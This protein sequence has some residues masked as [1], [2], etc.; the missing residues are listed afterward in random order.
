VPQAAT[1]LTRLKRSITP[2]ICFLLLLTAVFAGFFATPSSAQSA[3]AVVPCDDAVMPANSPPF[4]CNGYGLNTTYLI[5]EDR[6]KSCN[7]IQVVAIKITQH[8]IRVREGWAFV[9]SETEFTGTAFPPYDDYEF[10]VRLDVTGK[11]P[12]LYT[13]HIDYSWT[14]T[15]NAANSVNTATCTYSG[16]G[17]IPG[18]LT[19]N[20]VANV[21]FVD[22]VGPA[23]NLMNG[24]ITL[25]TSQLQ[26]ASNLTKGT[27][28][29]G[30]GADG[31]TEILIRIS[32]NSPNEQFQLTLMNDA[33]GVSNSSDEDGALGSP[34]DS[35]FTANQK[36]VS[37][38][39]AAPGQS[40]YAFAI[41][42]APIDFVRPGSKQGACMAP[43]IADSAA[44]CRSVSVK[45][46]DLTTNTSVGNYLVYIL[47]PPV[48]LIHGL[49][50]D[51]KAWD[52]FKPLIQGRQIY[53]FYTDSRFYARP[54]DYSIPPDPPIIGFT[55]GFANVFRSY[56]WIQSNAL[57]FV[58]NAPRVAVQVTRYLNTFKNGDNPLELPI[59]ASQVD[60][61]GHSM[62]G[63][64]ARQMV[65]QTGQK[66]Y[67]NS[68]NFGQGTIHKLITIDTPHLG[69][70]L[71]NKLIDP[72]NQCVRSV[73]EGS[74]SYSVNIATLSDGSSVR[75]AMADLAVL[76]NQSIQNL[77]ATGPK[78][79][80]AAL[81]AG[82]YTN[83][84]SLDC[85]GYS[86]FTGMSTS[87]HLACQGEPLEQSLNSSGWPLLFGPTG[88]NL[89][90]GIVSVTS[91]FNNGTSSLLYSS[92]V[93]TKALTSFW[94]GL[95]FTSPSVLDHASSPNGIADEVIT[96]LNTPISQAPF[97]PLNP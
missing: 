13:F 17:T 43:V 35:I 63:L 26:L 15:A 14:I 82:S 94:K 41:Y 60:I 44:S 48:V 77:Q 24:Y 80:S 42:R 64:I 55:P 73:F 33:G 50:S 96:L 86:C 12:G 54:V 83:W 22:P 85:S 19:L 32:T 8:S 57:G 47:R 46:Q 68:N 67:L 9:D 58:Y 51:W 49:W 52:D 36:T 5:S 93:H 39:T 18:I 11:P 10:T 4:D 37:A 28:I 34:G 53:R 16:N 7:G 81:L 89:N 75:G 74:G 45:V 91:Q 20:S 23:P 76:P 40:A 69:S 84:S 71:A 6:A 3:P 62:G 97:A 70:I 38:G 95:N 90:D 59:A 56:D 29:N 1:F 92:L 65:L 2:N 79:L 72:A 31:V 87:I 30:V 21:I 66:P 61:I 88:N 27:I 78:T 25:S